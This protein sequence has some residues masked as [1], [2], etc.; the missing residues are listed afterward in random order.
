[1][2]YSSYRRKRNNPTCRRA[3]SIINNVLNNAIYVEKHND[4]RHG[5]DKR[6]IELYAAVKSGNKLVRL[7]IVAREGDKNANEFEV[8]NA[9]YYDIIEE[10]MLPANAPKGTLPAHA[11]NNA[12]RQ[13]RGNIPSAVSVA[14]L[15]KNVKDRAGNPYID[16]NGKLVY[17]TKALAQKRLSA[18]EK[19]NKIAVTTQAKTLKD[20]V[21]E[22]GG[23]MSYLKSKKDELYK[24]WIDKNDTMHSFDEAVAIRWL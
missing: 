4:D 21:L 8:K 22:K 12:Q 19:S 2:V 14:E 1:M 9:E 16:A 15:L 24:D 11:R 6:Y 18:R 7:R 17:D 13:V 3:L 20:K 23:A 5:S 10:G